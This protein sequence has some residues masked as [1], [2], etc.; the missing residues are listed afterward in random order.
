MAMGKQA[1]ASWSSYNG[2]W[3]MIENTPS[4]RQSMLARLLERARTLPFLERLLE[5]YRR[6]AS[7]SGSATYWESRYVGGG[8]SGA[9]SYGQFADLKASVLNH[10]VEANGVTTVTEFGCGDGNQL[11]LMR[12]PSYTGFDVSETVV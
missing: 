3:K 10:F 2:A 5:G 1:S 6:D 12:Y 8:S 4:T 9:G 11:S 7:F